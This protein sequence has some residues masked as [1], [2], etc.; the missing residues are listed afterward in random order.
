[1]ADVTLIYEGTDITDNIAM[2]KVVI[3]RMVYDAINNPSI[4][5]GFISVD[6]TEEDLM[7]LLNQT[8]EDLETLEF[9]QNSSAGKIKADIIQKINKK[10]EG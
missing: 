8:A 2:E 9:D 6:K 4:A 3:A 7:N 1:M 10:T 5:E